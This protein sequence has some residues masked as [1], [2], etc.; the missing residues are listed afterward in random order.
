MCGRVTR[1]G[2]RGRG[3]SV[4]APPSQS[5][6]NLSPV[7][8]HTNK[9]TPHTIC[10]ISLHTFAAYFYHPHHT[11]SASLPLNLAR[12]P[13]QTQN[14][15]RRYTTVLLTHYSHTPPPPF[16]LSLSLSRARARALSLP[17]PFPNRPYSL[18]SFPLL[19]QTP[20]LRR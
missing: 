4:S 5:R 6:T 3:T 10:G 18:P 1:G 7:T 20:F 8:R 12:T 15:P 17:L 13:P 19:Q 14:S 16:S 9:S 11:K 2:G